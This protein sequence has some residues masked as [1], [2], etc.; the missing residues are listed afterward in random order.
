MPQQR[1]ILFVRRNGRVCRLSDTKGTG[2]HPRRRSNLLRLP[3][4]LRIKIYE[5]TVTRVNP[6]ALAELRPPPLAL[7]NRQ[8]FK[9]VLPV[10]FRMNAFTVDAS[11]TYLEKIPG[12][13]PMQFFARPRGV[14]VSTEPV[15]TTVQG[16]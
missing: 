5:Y 1:R 7:V 15:S 8:L 13:D 6:I 11:L 9:E 14:D 4:E 12:E 10:V 16:N 3:K 2:K